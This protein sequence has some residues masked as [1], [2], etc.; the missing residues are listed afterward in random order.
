MEGPIEVL[1]A[2]GLLQMCHQGALTG[3]LEATREAETIRMTFDKGRL[4]SATSDEAD[5]REAVVQFVGWT[6]GRFVFDPGATAEGAPISEPTNFL[7]LEACR[8]LD[9]KSA[10]RIET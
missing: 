3:A 5:G 2:P 6:E 4:A 10:T 9:E 8:L 1:G 7:I